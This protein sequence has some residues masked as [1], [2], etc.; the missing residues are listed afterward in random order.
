MKLLSPAKIN[1]FFRVLSKREDGFHEIETIMQAIDLF[2]VVEID[3]CECDDIALDKDNL[4]HRA[5]D[6]YRM[7]TGLHFPLKVRLKKNIPIE[8]GLGGGSGNA[9]TTLWGIN[10]LADGYL[11]QTD[12]SDLSS[13][14]G[15]DVPFFFSKGTAYCWGRGE[16][17][18]EVDPQGIDTL[19]IAKP[20]FGLKTPEVY[21]YCTPTEDAAHF[22][23]DLEKSAFFCA[24]KLKE[25]KEAILKLGFSKVMMT[26]SGSAFYC[27][28][29]ISKPFLP[30]VAF[31]KVNTIN[32]SDKE[33]YL[34]EKETL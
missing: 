14:L 30:G 21:R 16:M 28:G 7:E 12:L 8:A 23:N 17:L 10:Q 19:Y 20:D 2:D 25:I 15:S 27:I 6:L 1:L 31:T 34:S 3:Q 4:V 13:E 22:N 18:E 33:W 24:P 9:A 29:E 26:G 5:I 32:R 11:S